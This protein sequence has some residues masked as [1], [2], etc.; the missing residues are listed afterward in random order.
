MRTPLILTAVLAV[1]VLAVPA[2]ADSITVSS[3]DRTATLASA[4]SAFTGLGNP[5]A[6]AILSYYPGDPWT[7]VGDVNTGSAPTH[8][9]LSVTLDPGVSWGDNTDVSGT[10]AI[11]PAFWALYGEAVISMHAGNGNGNPDHWAWLVTPGHTSG[12][13]SYDD[14]DGRGGGLSNLMLWGRGTG[15]AVPEPASGLLLLGA[16]VGFVG[17]RRRRARS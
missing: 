2:Q 13:F 17:L 8:G 5:D 9:F 7:Q 3:A 15:S 12:T 10:W 1:L 11:H 6:A 16:L 4:E 14:F